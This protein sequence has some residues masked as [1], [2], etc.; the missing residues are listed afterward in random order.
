MRETRFGAEFDSDVKVADCGGGAHQVGHL[1]AEFFGGVPGIE[2]GE[3]AEALAEASDGD[4]QVV[5]GIGVCVARG[6]AHLKSEAAE[7][8]GG[9]ESGV[10]SH[11]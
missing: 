7:E 6:A 10:V 8:D 5:D 9:L 1:P 2:L 3:D 4:T 11:I